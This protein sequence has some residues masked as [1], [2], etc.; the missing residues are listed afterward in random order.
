M[1]WCICCVLVHG[2]ALQSPVIFWCM[3]KH[4][5]HQWYSGAWSG[6]TITSDILVHGQALQL[7]VIFWCMVKHYNYQWYSGAWSSTTITSDI[8][9]HGQALQSLVF[10]CMVKHYNHQWYS[11]AWSGT[12]ITSDIL[13]HG[14]ALQSP[15]IFW[16]MVWHFSEISRVSAGRLGT[17]TYMTPHIS[18][19]SLHNIWL[20]EKHWMLYNLPSEFFVK[21]TRLVTSNFLLLM[22]CTNKVIV[23]SSCRIV[24]CIALIDWLCP[25][26][27]TSA[28]LIYCWIVSVNSHHRT[29]SCWL[30][31]PYLAPNI[32][33]YV[34]HILHHM[35]NWNVNI[36]VCRYRKSGIK[37]C[38]TIQ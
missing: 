23:L 20:P 34:P 16:C 12:T 7:P 1:M 21:L 36:N 10:Y 33:H 27:S 37:L 2:Q 14:Q 4:Y 11:G 35:D 29:V 17:H 24:S 5:N 22:L 25:I 38:N 18:R 28:H 32:K 26:S 9:V 31:S 30:G 3:V 8:L 6:T 19:A 15:V 13:V